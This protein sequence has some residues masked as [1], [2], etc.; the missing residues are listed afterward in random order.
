MKTYA[1]VKEALTYLGYLAVIL[2]GLFALAMGA[3][4]LLG[5][6]TPFT[7]AASAPTQ[8]YVVEFGGIS[9]PLVITADCTEAPRSAALA[10]GV[11]DLDN[12]H[13]HAVTPEQWGA[14]SPGD[15]YQ[16]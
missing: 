11:C 9:T 1:V 6:P 12:L 7:P 3:S 16:Q 15:A 2:G 5:I 8:E 14:Y 13:V 4:I 10:R